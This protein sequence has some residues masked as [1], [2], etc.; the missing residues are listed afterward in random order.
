MVAQRTYGKQGADLEKLARIFKR[1][2]CC[3]HPDDVVKAIGEWILNGGG[4][5]PTPYDIKNMLD[6]HP[7]SD[8]ALY[9]RLLNKKKNDPYGMTHKEDKYITWYEQDC[10]RGL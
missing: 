1:V 3:Y 8:Y 9:S 5:F 6:P 2:L 4:D 7:K 10:M